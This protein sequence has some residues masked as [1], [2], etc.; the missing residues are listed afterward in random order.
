[1]V[2]LEAEG[3]TLKAIQNFWNSTSATT[4]TSAAENCNFHVHPSQTNPME[5]QPEP[6]L[7][8]GYTIL[9]SKEIMLN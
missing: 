5:C 6:V 9:L 3:H 1:M 7:Q 4:S 2:Q 8:I